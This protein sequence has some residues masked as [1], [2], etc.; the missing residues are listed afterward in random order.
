MPKIRNGPIEPQELSPS[1]VEGAIEM[2]AAPV[3][4][5][6]AEAAKSL[7]QLQQGTIKTGK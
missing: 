4:Q 1:R 6:G 3:R 7:D 5:M 2:D